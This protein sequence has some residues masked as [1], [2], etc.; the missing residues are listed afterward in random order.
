M[1][2]RG[3]RDAGRDESEGNGGG[4]SNLAY[5]SLTPED[6]LAAVESVGYRCDGR[7]L[8]LNSY[9]NR[10]YRV[11]LEEGSP[12]VA[13]FY[14]PGRWSDAAIRE[15]HAFALELAAAELPVVAPLEHGGA[16]L[17][18]RVPFRFARS[19]ASADDL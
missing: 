10:V 6:V 11:G 9:E 5:Q 13:K 8:A 2:S 15:E 4:Q 19:T 17:H 7:T 1:G 16:T 18:H 3:R 14:R 12:I